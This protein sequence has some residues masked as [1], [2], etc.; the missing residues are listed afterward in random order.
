M[1]TTYA[2]IFLASLALLVFA[3][4]PVLAGDIKDKAEDLADDAKEKVEEEHQRILDIP[5]LPH[6]YAIPITVVVGIFI[7]FLLG[8]RKGKR[9]EKA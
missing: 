5:L 3:A 6:A 1:R 7:G 9:K 4:A 8:K 2:A